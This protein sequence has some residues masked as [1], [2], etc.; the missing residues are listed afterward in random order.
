MMKDIAL[1]GPTRKKEDVLNTAARNA[2][3]HQ[4]R[5]RLQ[6][7]QLVGDRKGAEDFVEGAKESQ[8]HRI[9]KER[10]QAQ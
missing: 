10:V 5:V 6:V 8:R 9:I 4:K 3:E 1:H 2:N 7:E